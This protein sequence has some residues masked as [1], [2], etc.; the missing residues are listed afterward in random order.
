MK[1]YKEYLEEKKSKEGTV[2][3]KQPEK[4]NMWAMDNIL[5]KAE[6]AKP[7]AAAPTT[8]K[9][10]TFDMPAVLKG[11]NYQE[12]NYYQNMLDDMYAGNYASAK[13][14]EMLHNEKNGY[15]GLGYEN[16]H[17]FNYDDPYLGELNR[18]RK[19]I[20]NRDPF[21]YD[22]RQDD[23]YKSILSQKEKEADQAYKDGYA[24]LSRQFDGDIP[25]NMLNKLYATKGE[26]IDQ[27]DSYIPQL[28][29]MAYDMY[30]QE[31]NKMLTDYNLT[32]QLADEDYA[33]W[34]DEQN[35]V[36]SGLENKYARDKYAKEFD[37]NKE[38]R[39]LG[40]LHDSEILD[41]QLAHTTA[42]RVA[43]QEY[44]SAEAEK[45]RTFQKEMQNLVNSVGIKDAIT[46][47]AVELFRSEQY[48]WE[49]AF[50][51]ASQLVEFY[52]K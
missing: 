39:D 35:T 31:G 50:A 22:Y 15:M 20:E 36:I 28:R 13:Y 26:I 2:P 16:S 32:K 51:T 47:V 33:R 46:N 27:A 30:N 4:T 44:T 14:N 18:Q 12:A 29:Q 19:A 49:S 11:K 45:E 8:A 34:K 43:N 17:I 5:P 48:S 41:K 52:G 40:W 24:Q 6:I 37:Y 9:Q 7:V 3:Y 23:L 1:T 10:P 21:S 42:E 38:T 25:V